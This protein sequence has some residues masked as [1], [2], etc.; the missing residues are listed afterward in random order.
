MRAPIH[1]YCSLLRIQVK[2]ALSRTRSRAFGVTS[3]EIDYT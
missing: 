3:K 1:V 2:E